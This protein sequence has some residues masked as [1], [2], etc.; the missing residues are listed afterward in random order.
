VVGALVRPDGLLFAVGGDTTVSEGALGIAEGDLV[1]FT[2]A[3][4]G[5]SWHELAR[6][7]RSW[8]RFGAA[9]FF[10][11]GEGSHLV[12]QRGARATATPPCSSRWSE[13]LFLGEGG[14]PERTSCFEAPETVPSPAALDAVEERCGCPDHG[15][16]CVTHTTRG[17]RDGY[18]TLRPSLAV[19]RTRTSFGALGAPT[20]DD[21]DRYVEP[22]LPP[23]VH[24]IRAHAPPSC[25]SDAART[26]RPVVGIR[27][28][29]LGVLRVAELPDGLDLDRV[30][31]AGGMAVVLA[32]GAEGERVLTL[33]AEGAWFD[34]GALPFDTGSL[35]RAE[36]GT[37]VLVEGSAPSRGARA[38]LRAPVEPGAPG[39]WSD[40]SRRSAVAYAPIAGGRALVAEDDAPRGAPRGDLSISVVDATARRLLTAVHVDRD[41]EE[42]EAAFDGEHLF[43]H[44]TRDGPWLA[45]GRDGAAT[46]TSSCLAYGRCDDAD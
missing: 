23:G 11:D 16:G 35:L 33:D 39:A 19:P 41:P 14:A 46:P 38:W 42:T 18:V 28:A 8:S 34:E 21:R 15:G 12:T 4:R 37:L 5:G 45:V 1:A 24:Q 32:R 2:S 10:E 17:W 36:D 29:G 31:D 25:R 7:V 43:L 44:T 27:D 30:L 40:V 9:I 22:P 13:A 26:S 20:C 6:G 3:D